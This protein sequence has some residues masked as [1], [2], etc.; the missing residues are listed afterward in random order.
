M[1]E[2]YVSFQISRK[3]FL[4]LSGSTIHAQKKRLFLKTLQTMHLLFLLH[5]RTDH[6]GGKQMQLLKRMQNLWGRK[7][8]ER[9]S[10]KH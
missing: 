6:D 7:V 2:V 8:M 3:V 1:H 9:K 5:V 10:H 4:V